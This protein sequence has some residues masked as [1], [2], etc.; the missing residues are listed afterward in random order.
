MNQEILRQ[1]QRNDLRAQLTEKTKLLQS[2]ITRI[3]RS[4]QSELYT[5]GYERSNL[6]TT[7]HSQLGLLE[8]EIQQ[9]ELVHAKTRQLLENQ[10]AEVNA[11]RDATLQFVC[12]QQF[13]IDKDLKDSHVKLYR[14][15]AD[16]EKILLRSNET[17]IDVSYQTAALRLQQHSQAFEFQKANSAVL[18]ALNIE[19]AKAEE[20]F[21]AEESELEAKCMDEL[22]MHKGN[23]LKLKQRKLQL[24]NQ[25]RTA[26]AK[27]EQQ[28]VLVWQR[29]SIILLE[30]YKELAESRRP[31]LVELKAIDQVCLAALKREKYDGF[32][33]TPILHGEASAR[34]AKLSAKFLRKRYSGLR[35]QQFK[36]ELEERSLVLELHL[37][38]SK[39]HFNQ[40]INWTNDDHFVAVRSFHHEHQDLSLSL[41][42]ALLPGRFREEELM[43]SA[44]QMQNSLDLQRLQLDSNRSKAANHEM[45]RMLTLQKLWIEEVGLLESRLVLLESEEHLLLYKSKAHKLDFHCSSGAH[46]LSWLQ[47]SIS[48]QRKQLSELRCNY[49][50]RFSVILNSLA[51]IAKQHEHLAE[52]LSKRKEALRISENEQ[53]K[54]I[55]A[56]RAALTTIYQTQIHHVDMRI[57]AHEKARQAKLNEINFLRAIVAAPY[58]E[59]LAEADGQQQRIDEALKLQSKH[60]AARTVLNLGGNLW[61]ISG[62]F[63]G[64][65]NFAAYGPR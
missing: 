39:K 50:A 44:E 61:S 38:N 40:H 15:L 9:S 28:S 63:Q 65:D 25:F 54:S 41:Q 8:Q 42:A 20:S 35:L 11:R 58:R 60:A 5:I 57:A 43:L 13:A 24:I 22:V 29:Y 12:E 18:H 26:L 21:H 10:I 55:L 34:L 1:K 59:A 62:N 32:D 30:K 52:R 7:L 17:D 56:E 2:Q 3:E 27:L 36:H 19:R 47:A 53:I 46:R 33:K 16:I 4:R 45:A 64:R 51:N 37:G 23:L 48:Q 49:N 31:L 14:Q 6:K